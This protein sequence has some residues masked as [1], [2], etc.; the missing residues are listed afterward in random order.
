MQFTV[1]S[2][3]HLTNYIGWHKGGP[4]SII[5]FHRTLIMKATIEF[6][7]L[8]LLGEVGAIVAPLTLSSSQLLPS[9]IFIIIII[10]YLFIYLYLFF[11]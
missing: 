6:L 10:I 8:L 3:S 9:C 2:R 7:L 1:W 11:K 4:C 5:Q